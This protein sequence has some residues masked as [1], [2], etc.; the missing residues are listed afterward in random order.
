MRKTAKTIRI[1]LTAKT[2]LERDELSARNEGKE[3]YIHTT[4]RKYLRISDKKLHL[5]PLLS[6]LM[7]LLMNLLMICRF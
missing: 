5:Q 1:R 4:N 2:V 6:F 7:I 3:E